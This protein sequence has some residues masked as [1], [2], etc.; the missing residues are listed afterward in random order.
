MALIGCPDCGKSVSDIAP[1]CPGCGRPMLNA[2]TIEATGKKW[3]AIQ[4]WGK[5]GLALGFLLLL[6]NAGS[7][8]L[9]FSGFLVA[10]VGLVALC[11]GRQGAWWHHG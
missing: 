7:G 11:Y 1:T 9:L 6:F 4:A 10:G 3:K 2:T 8:F 5:G